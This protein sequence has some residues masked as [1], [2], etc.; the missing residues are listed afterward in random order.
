MCEESR[1]GDMGVGKEWRA[2]I[3]ELSVLVKG[4]FTEEAPGM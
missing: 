3:G 4:L 2:C 1:R